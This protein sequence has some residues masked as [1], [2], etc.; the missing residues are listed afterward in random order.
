MTSISSPG[1]TVDV[2]GITTAGSLY[3]SATRV[4]DTVYVSGQVSFTDDGRIHGEGDVSAQ[5]RHSVARL[6]RVLAVYAATLDDV[7]SCTVYLKDAS[8][9]ESFNAAWGAAFG[10]HRPSRATVVAQLLDQR[11]LV[12]VQAIARLQRSSSADAGR[13]K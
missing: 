3:P 12:E 11:L 2:E 13:E 4:G 7:V 1:R 10:R 6:A 8:L 9:A 5:T